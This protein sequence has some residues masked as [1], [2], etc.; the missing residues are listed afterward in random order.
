MK[1][2]RGCDAVLPPQRG[3]G[4][5][6]VWCTDRCRK[7]TLYGRPCRD[8]GKAL[9]GSDGT[10]PNAPV[11]C[12]SCHCVHTRKLTRQWVLD[13]FAEWHAMFGRAPVVAEWTPSMA[14]QRGRDDY[15]AQYEAT[16]RPWPTQATVTNHFGSWNAAV[17]A[18][19]FNPLP[20]GRY[21]DEST[22][23]V[24]A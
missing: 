24:A 19:G 18:A 8:C 16:G 13:S 2:C 11:R 14:A 9:N 17:A 5:E 10:G 21:R 15:L 12:A 20:P 1:T 7:Q 3:P 23:R 22:R 4:R 6:R